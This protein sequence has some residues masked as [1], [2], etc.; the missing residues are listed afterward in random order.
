MK[1][2]RRKQRARTVDQLYEVYA[3]ALEAITMTDSSKFV[4]HAMEFLK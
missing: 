2:H 4:A 1:I 3:E